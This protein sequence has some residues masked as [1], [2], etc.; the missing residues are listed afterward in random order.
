MHTFR[1]KLQ[2]NLYKAV[3]ALTLFFIVFIEAGTIVTAQSQVFADILSPVMR[4]L[5]PILIALLL[6][7]SLLIL[8][9][10]LDKMGKKGLWIY[11]GILFVILLAGFGVI[12]SNFFPFSSTDAYNMQDMAMYLAKTG[13]KPISDTAP[14]ASY[15]GMFSNNYFLTVIFAKFI[16]MLSRAG[17]TEVQFALLAL[18]VAGMIIATIFLYLTGIRIGGL[19]GGAKILTLCV[20]NPIYYILPM[21]IYT[22]S[23]SIP[24]TAAVIYFG[25]RLLKEESWKDRVISAI[26]FAVFGI[27]GYYIRPTVVIPMIAFVFCYILD[28]LIGKKKIKESIQSF[29]IV[30]LI[31]IVVSHGISGLNQ[32]YFETVSAQN[33]PITHWLMMASHGDGEHNKEDYAYTHQFRTKEEKT[34]ATVD[35][36]IKNYKSYS[37][38]E[39]MAFEQKKLMVSW[40]YADGG[41]LIEKISQDQKNTPLYTWILGSRFDLFRA[42]CYGFRI[43][44]MAFL[45]LALWRLLKRKKEDILQ[46]F[47]AVSI[48]GG[49]LFYCIW[50]IKSSYGMPFVMLFLLLGMAGIDESKEKLFQKRNE[51]CAY[52]CGWTELV[53]LVCVI[54]ICL[55]SGEQMRKSKIPVYQWSVHCIN[56]TSA[57]KM[58]DVGKTVHINQ[59]FE[60]L[61]SFNRIGL[62]VSAGDRAKE[63]N[64]ILQVQ[65]TDEKGNRIYRGKIQADK[66]GEHGSVIL[67]FPKV[68]PTKENKDYHLRIWNK[69]PHKGKLRVWYRKEFYMHSYKGKLEVDGRNHFENLYLQVYK[70]TKEPW[71]DKKQ[72]L[73]IAGIFLLWTAIVLVIIPKKRCNEN[74][75]RGER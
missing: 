20:L 9:R 52:K 23:F 10:C 29:G 15:F 56:G 12:L 35:R 74:V 21:W 28:H 16:N 54:C 61:H 58:E 33:Y 31:G 50:E 48:L 65:L 19:K 62:I 59:K 8:F 34:Q 64:D 42:Y 11:T 68:T 17:I 36:M 57:K 6:G 26:L 70:E 73:V 3:M 67:K 7:S 37:F 47:W 66:V 53:L 63:F 5:L 38:S 13:E 30:L 27:T 51:K 14:H 45:C 75:E 24:F 4:L 60:A 25:V 18:S 39:L 44:N 72:M 69:K 49:I 1:M 46:V 41:D 2:L 32:S 71:C 22:C 43:S 40:C 55:V